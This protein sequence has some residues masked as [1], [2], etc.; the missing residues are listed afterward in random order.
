MSS[1]VACNFLGRLAAI[2]SQK[3]SRWKGN[4]TSYQAFNTHRSSCLYMTR[5]SNR[6]FCHVPLSRWTQA[7]EGGEESISW[8]KVGL[9]ISSFQ[10]KLPP[11]QSSRWIVGL[12]LFT[13]FIVA[14]L[15]GQTMNFIH[16]VVVVYICHKRINQ[17]LVYFQWASFVL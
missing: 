5:M 7:P 13:R 11:S 4:L 17:I 10:L 15:P 12:Q 16:L 1:R 2:P 14:S 8:S 9:C 3:G 6:R